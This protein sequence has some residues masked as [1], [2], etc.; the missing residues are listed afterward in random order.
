MEEESTRGIGAVIPSERLISNLDYHREGQ[1]LIISTDETIQLVDSLAGLEKKKIYCKSLGI[2]KA[3]YTHHDASIL[4]SSNNPARN[5]DVKY[6]SLHDNRYLKVFKGHGSD[7]IRSISMSP[8][9]DNF[10]TSTNRQVMLWSLSSPNSSP[11][12]T[13][14]L[15]NYFE[16]VMVSYDGSGVV[17][18]VMATDQRNR[19]HYLRLYNT[20]Q[21][22]TGPFAEMAPSVTNLTSAIM[23]RMPG[24]PPGFVQK[25]IRSTWTDFQFS[26]EGEKILVNTNS[27]AVFVIDG[28]NNTNESLCIPRV[29]S[30]GIKLSASFSTDAN[31]ILLGTEDNDISIYNSLRADLSQTLTGHVSPVGV[32]A[33]NPKYD[34]IATACVNCALWLPI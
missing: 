34:V 15:P 31:E 5:N 20:A 13:I 25:V 4:V 29:N 11:I 28:Y 10:L 9:N 19:N 17:F 7:P 12:A 27:D 16:N 1:Y 3:K 30:N 22:S 14:N 32:I 6:L 2:G 33:C 18:G 24:A 21:Y 23:K 8:I 26:G